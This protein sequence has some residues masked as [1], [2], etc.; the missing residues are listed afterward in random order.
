MLRSS[1]TIA[2]TAMSMPRLTCIALAPA[3]MFL[4]PSSKMLSARIV[5]VVVP[6]PATVEVFDATS[7][8]IWAPMFS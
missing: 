4:S 7:L 5:A 2:S 3:V 8:T 6:S 1:S